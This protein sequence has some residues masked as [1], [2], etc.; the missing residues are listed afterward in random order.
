M[1]ISIWCV[2]RRISHYSGLKQ[3]SLGS[4]SKTVTIAKLTGTEV[5]KPRRGITPARGQIT[6]MKRANTEASLRKTGLV[7]ECFQQGNTTES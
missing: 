3:E 4:W 5:A 7:R 2:F 1:I 6:R